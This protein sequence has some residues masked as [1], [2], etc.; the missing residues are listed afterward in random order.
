M[1]KDVEVI[2]MLYNIKYFIILH[3]NLE[4]QLENWEDNISIAIIITQ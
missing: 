1:A 4:G 2:I 3:I